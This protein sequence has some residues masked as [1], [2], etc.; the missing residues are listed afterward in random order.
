VRAFAD[1]FLRLGGGAWLLLQITK[2]WVDLSHLLAR[3]AGLDQA[4]AP[5]RDELKA[6]SSQL[7]ADIAASS[8]QLRADMAAYSTQLRADMAASSTQ[9]RADMTV[10]GNKVERLQVVVVGVAVLGAWLGR[11]PGAGRG[12]K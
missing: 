4:T 9:L 1:N 12:A 6:S 11:K 7:R 10:L 2:T 5:L 3:T 8:T